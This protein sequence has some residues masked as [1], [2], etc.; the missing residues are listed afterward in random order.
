MRDLAPTIALTTFVLGGIFIALAA[1]PGKGKVVAVFEPD[2]EPHAL[3]AAIV[4]ADARFIGSGAMPGTV[5]VWS[6]EP[7]LP[8]RLRRA[9]AL[10]VLNPLVAAGCGMSP[11]PTPSPLSKAG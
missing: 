9:G 5:M 8:G 2:I 4:R 7:D 6:G 3:M 10:F 1:P 11:P